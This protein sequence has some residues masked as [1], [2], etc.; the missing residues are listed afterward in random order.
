[1]LALLIILIKTAFVLWLSGVFL[2]IAYIVQQIVL[3]VDVRRILLRNGVENAIWHILTTAVKWPPFAL[4]VWK[5]NRD[6]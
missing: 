3:Y 2:C 1:M 5:A 4:S 6:Y